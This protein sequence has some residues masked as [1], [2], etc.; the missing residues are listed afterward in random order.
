MSENGVNLAPTPLKHD[1]FALGQETLT[2]IGRQYLEITEPANAGRL[3]D[4]SRPDGRP[5]DHPGSVAFDRRL[6]ASGATGKV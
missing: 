4:R 1:G 5:P 3:A 2:A 6:A